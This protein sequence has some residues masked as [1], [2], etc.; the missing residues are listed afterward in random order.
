MYHTITLLYR[1]KGS[2]YDWTQMTHDVGHYISTADFL[3]QE[4][5]E[6]GGWEYDPASVTREWPKFAWP[7]G[8]DI[9]NVVA[10]GG[11]LCVDCSNKE[12]PRTLDA[13]DEQFHVVGQDCNWEDPQLYCDH[14]NRR[15]PSAYADDTTED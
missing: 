1:R 2:S 3:K 8:Y 12:F 4:Y 5:P 15:I 13:E 10:D 7:G 11:V 9:F 14:C 6:S